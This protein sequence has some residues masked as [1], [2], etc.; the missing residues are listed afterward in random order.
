MILKDRFLGETLIDDEIAIKIINS[1]EMQR[2]KG[3][4]IGGYYPAHPEV[5][6]KVSRFEH[7]VG[8]Y[9]LLKE[10]GASE[11]EQLSG[12]LHDVS[13]SAFSHT[14]D[15]VVKSEGNNVAKQDF[16]DKIHLDFIKNSSIFEILKNGGFN[17]DFLAETMNFKLLDNDL[18]DV[19]A[20]R[21]DYALRSAVNIENYDLKNIEKILNGL[22]VKDDKF[23]FK[24]FASAQI[25]YDLF[26]L[27][28]SNYW[29]GQRSAVMFFLDRQLLRYA[30]KKNYIKFED[31]YR[32]TD[33]EIIDKIS[34]HKSDTEIQKW[35]SFLHDK[36][37]KQ[38]LTPDESK[39]KE[40]IDIKFR[41]INP[42][43]IIDN[44]TKH[45]SD[46]NAEIKHNL[47]VNTPAFLTHNIYFNQP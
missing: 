8:V 40:Q 5:A 39:F 18:P 4:A 26:E 45:L 37:Y 3:V 20:D 35:L 19:C 12:L 43:V 9:L 23:V 24:D 1:P 44:E 47:A 17:V 46:I 10:F 2:L 28:N 25:F 32:F 14:I 41:R 22:T 6:H 27:E 21:I 34:Q 11:E 16:Q 29:A 38:F 42:L 15:Y 30:L 31:F 13:H 36:N 7:S 33:T